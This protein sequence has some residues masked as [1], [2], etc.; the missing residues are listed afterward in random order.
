VAPLIRRVTLV[1]NPASRRGLRQRERT[2]GAFRRAGVTVDV[3]VTEH[4]GHART[5]LA[6]VSGDRD[7]VFV[8]GGDGTVREVAGALSGTGVPIGVLP[9]GTGNLVAGELGVPRRLSRAVPALLR[10]GVRRIDL[11][12]LSD[13]SS[14]VFAAGIGIDVDM[15]R[16]TSRGRKRTLGMLGY[17]V[18]ASRSAFRRRAFDLTAT[19]DGDIIHERVVLAMAANGGSLFGGRLELG[20]SISPD[21]G[22]LD[23][24]LYSP[25]TVSDVLGIT[26]RILRRDFSPHPRM[27]FL[28]GK[29]IAF[30]CDPP[31]AFQADGDIAGQTPVEMEVVAGAAAF[32]VPSP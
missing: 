21:D 15:V 8:L 17:A 27:R 22:V 18:T 7:A 26:A 28:R 9:G 23:L 12:R 11:G 16:G 10:G 19:V 29:R 13:G 20:P 24:C 5:L 32:L 6:G 3:C 1:V 30:S 4:P 25:V 2:L 14:F 31:T